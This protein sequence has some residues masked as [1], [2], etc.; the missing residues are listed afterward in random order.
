MAVKSRRNALTSVPLDVDVRRGWKHDSFV[1]VLHERLRE[2]DGQR[3]G[4]R[5]KARLKVATIE[6]LDELGYRDMKVVD[7]CK[8]ADVTAAVLYLYYD[9]KLSLVLDVLTEFLNEFFATA[10]TPRSNSL[11]EA[12]RLANLRW[13]RLARVNSGL[14]RCLLEASN[15]EPSFGKLY[16]EANHK[17]YQRS[18]QVWQARYAREE[19][20][21]RAALL[22]SYSLGGL[23][24]EVVRLLFIAKDTHVVDAVTSLELA[25][26]QLAEYI[27][28]IWYRA[29]TAQDPPRAPTRVT[30]LFRPLREVIAAPDER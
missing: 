9:N 13:L 18:V 4:D 7:I 2:T 19:F 15:D 21:P 27:S 8:R 23:L 22:L 3:K 14:M 30:E 16:S 17:W 29:L 5:T 20:D 24:D 25:D 11:F 12:I 28:L 1:E 26:E 6:A 10:K